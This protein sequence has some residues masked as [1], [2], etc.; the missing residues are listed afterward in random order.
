MA[1]AKL[2]LPSFLRAMTP[3]NNNIL[4]PIWPLYN[5]AYRPLGI[6]R[7]NSILLLAH[8]GGLELAMTARFNPM[9]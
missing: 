3:A 8:Q 4:L 6:V 2:Q 5:A 1:G 7:V 9:R